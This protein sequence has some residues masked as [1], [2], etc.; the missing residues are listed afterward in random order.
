[1]PIANFSLLLLIKV[2]LIKNK[3]VWHK[4]LSPR[5][6][7]NS[8]FL[9]C[10]EFLC[11]ISI[12]R[13]V[14]SSRPEVFC[15]KSVFTN[16]ANII[17]KHRCQILFFNKVARWRPATYVFSNWS[18]PTYLK[19]TPSQ[20]FQITFKIAERVSALESLF[21]KV[22]KLISLFCNSVENKILTKFLES[23]L[24]I[25]ENFQYRTRNYNLQP[26]MFLKFW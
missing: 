19:L 7:A 6:I 8:F 12:R 14:K 4:S 17:R 1:M 26:C 24:K 5:K 22:T 2:L 3:S 21:G 13:S 23:I 16:F 10:S 15:D 20:I 9:Q 25:P 11:S 18:S